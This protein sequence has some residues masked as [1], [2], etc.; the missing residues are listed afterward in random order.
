[1]KNLKKSDL[2]AVVLCL[3]AMI[4]GAAVYSRLPDRIVSRWNLSWE[5]ADTMPK[6]F[7]VFG[8]P[9]IFAALMFL[10]CLFAEKQ[11]QKLAGGKLAAVLRI[12]MPAILYLSY[13]VMLLYALGKLKDVRFLVCLFFSVFCIIFG[14]YLPKVRKNWFVGI[15]TPHT[16]KD[17]DTWFRTHR[18]GGLLLTAGGL[19]ALITTVLGHFTLTLV[20]FAAAALIPVVYGEVYY[21]CA[22]RK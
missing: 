6:A 11:E 10:C 18:L 3:C 22:K 21:Y 14:N 2:I 4:P 12:L 15:R 13:G 8:I 9:L 1:M 16:L 19:L 17:E 20:I 5:P 7:A